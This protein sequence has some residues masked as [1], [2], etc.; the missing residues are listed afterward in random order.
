MTTTD[1]TLSLLRKRA[2]REKRP[3][4]RPAEARPAPGP[5]QRMQKAYRPSTGDSG[6]S[7]AIRFREVIEAA[8]Y[9]GELEVVLRDVDQAFKDG[10]LTA[11]EADQLIRLAQKRSQEVP[12]KVPD[13]GFS[14]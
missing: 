3:D 7:T 6:G 8:R 2:A 11:G 10:I 1:A 13:R 4:E 9:W 14:Q 12:E 5:T